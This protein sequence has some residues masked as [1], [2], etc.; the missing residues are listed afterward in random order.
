MVEIVIPLYHSRKTLPKALDS[1]VAQTK[2]K[3]ITC[4]SLDGEEISEYKDIIDTYKAR[5][6]KIRA[7]TQENQG[8]GMARQHGID[9]TQCDYIMFMDADDMLYPRAIEVLY[10][11]AKLGNYDMVRSSFLEEKKYSHDILKDISNTSITWSHGKIYKV[12]YLRKNNIRF[13]DGLLRNEDAYFNAIAWN[14]TE[15]KGETNEITYLWRDNLESITRCRP[16]EEFFKENT[17]EY[18]R[19]QIIAMKRVYELN[20]NINDEFFLQ[21]IINIYHYYNAAKFY[22]LDINKIDNIIMEM[23]N[24]DFLQDIFKKYN[25]WVYIFNNI[26]P[27]IVIK[28][29][30]LF[31]KET[32]DEWYRRLIKA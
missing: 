23:K 29:N 15:N 32:F 7:I 3:F 26:G 20:K 5:G 21:T 11:E 2:D 25:G 30:F 1:L 31:F 17:A 28:D 19:S 6:L 13:L 10:L 27:G 4:L 18:M 24:Y 16:I 9:T 14:G 8:P 22:Q 12:E